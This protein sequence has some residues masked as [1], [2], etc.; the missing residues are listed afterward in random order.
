MKTPS[1]RRFSALVLCVLLVVVGASLYLVLR[2][3]NDKERAAVLEEAVASAPIGDGVR[4][5]STLTRGHTCRLWTVVCEGL[6]VSHNY[7]S[8]KS[9]CVSLSETIA[10]WQQQ[11]LSL[12]QHDERR[13][14][15]SGMIHNIC[16]RANPWDTNAQMFSIGALFKPASRCAVPFPS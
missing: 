10:A 12:V 11:G 2:A 16:V 1:T 13:C 4:L 14:Y 7:L 5:S 15:F 8:T 3:P 6:A 9:G